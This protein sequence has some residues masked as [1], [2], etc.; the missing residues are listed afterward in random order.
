MHEASGQSQCHVLTSLVRMGARP[1]FSIDDQ[2][3][4][5]VPG[6]LGRERLGESGQE[7]SVGRKSVE[8]WY[9]VWKM[10]VNGDTVSRN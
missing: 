6:G 4:G 5:K 9:M 10:M 1:P 3:D 8:V 7:I 2:D